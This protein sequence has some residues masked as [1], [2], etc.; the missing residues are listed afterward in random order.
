[1]GNRINDISR[2]MIFAELAEMPSLTFIQQL[3]V[4]TAIERIEGMGWHRG[5]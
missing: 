5:D 3:E 2:Q 1:L 4:K